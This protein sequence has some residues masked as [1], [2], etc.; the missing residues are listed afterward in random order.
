MSDKSNIPD[1][2]A[3]GMAGRTEAKESRSG[4]VVEMARQKVTVGITTYNRFG[5]LHQA[6]ASVAGQTCPARVHIFD[7]GSS[8]PPPTIQ[9]GRLPVVVEISPHN[10][11]LLAARN[12][13]MRAAA[14]NGSTYY[15]SLDDDAWFLD[16][17][18]LATAVAMMQDN[19]KVA[20]LGFSI[21]SPD[22]P[23]RSSR[24]PARVIDSFIGCGHL[25][26]LE[27]VLPLGGYSP[28]PGFY[29]G[30]EKELSLRLLDRGWEVVFLPGV[31]V[32]HDK[33]P[34]ARDLPRQHRSGVCNDLVLT[35][36][37]FPLPAIAWLL[38]AKILSHLR[39][40]LLRSLMR[41][42]LQGIGDFISAVPSILRNREPVSSAALREF[43]RK[44]RRVGSAGQPEPFGTQY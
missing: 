35:L 27:A 4:Q 40:S 11:G 17:D 23:A 30:E 28:M 44:D 25:L 7:D 21:C 2:V 22:R 33:T 6:V 14:S 39:F 41:P 15:C 16:P 29:G 12:R 13:L 37:R 10:I 1:L 42:C 43:R 3:G 18:A 26:R 20:A 36:R 9:Q 5:L 19:P 24:G 38:P 34:V 32:W 31:H 8:T